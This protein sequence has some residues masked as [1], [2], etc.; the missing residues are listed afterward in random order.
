M[1]HLYEKKLFDWAWIFDAWEDWN[2]VLV[3]YYIDNKI[4]V[5]KTQKKGV[6]KDS[7]MLIYT[8]PL[9]S[10]FC[11]SLHFCDELFRSGQAYKRTEVDIKKNFCLIEMINY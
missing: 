11:F 1:Q 8:G 3:M 10:L 4:I 5:N 2:H 7:L 6:R 9:I